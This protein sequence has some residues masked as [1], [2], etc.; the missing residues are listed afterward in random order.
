MNKVLKT[1]I[2]EKNI[3][4]GIAFTNIYIRS[5]TNTIIKN[6]LEIQVILTIFKKKNHRY[7]I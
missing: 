6:V 2:L 7:S 5:V 3:R 4:M 1:I